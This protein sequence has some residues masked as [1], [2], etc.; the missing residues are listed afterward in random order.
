MH[1]CTP[2]ACGRGR[3]PLGYALNRT[4]LQC[5]KLRAP[6]C[7]SP[8]LRQS[9]APTVAGSAMAGSRKRKAGSTPPAAAAA[10]TRE[11]HLAALHSWLLAAGG[12]IHPSLR[13]GEDGWGGV[14]VFAEQHITAETDLI[15]V[16]RQCIISPETVRRDPATANRDLRPPAHRPAAPLIRSCPRAVRQIRE[17]RLGRELCDAVRAL[18][19]ELADEEAVEIATW[20]FMVAGR[21]ERDESHAPSSQRPTLACSAHEHMS[22]MSMHMRMRMNMCTWCIAH[23]RVHACTRTVL[24]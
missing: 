8:K 21:W 17:S 4:D 7:L 16:P 20:I 10:P 1:R 18:D 24:W 22:S 3:A 9:D 5:T 13:F 23:V 6:Y 14:G 19:S 2:S 11:A 12:T 15:F